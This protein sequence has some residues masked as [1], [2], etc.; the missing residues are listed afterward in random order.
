M[1]DKGV[2]MHEDSDERVQPKY[3]IKYL[4]ADRGKIQTELEEQIK[5]L[6]LEDNVKML[7]FRT[8]VAD[9]FAASDIYVFPSH[10]EG[11]PVA[12]MEAM[13][14]GMPVVCSKIRGNTDLIQEGEGGYLFDSKDAKSLV[15]ALNKALVD[16]ETRRSEM[17]QINVETMKSFD[18][19]CVNNV[20]KDL[21]SN[22]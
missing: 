11:L 22:L 6:G 7:G 4:I 9:V 19:T 10:Q 15:A 5:N 16:N 8:D 18:K 14:V 17:G 2:L 1:K 13:S 21:Y 20:M 3:N 12:L